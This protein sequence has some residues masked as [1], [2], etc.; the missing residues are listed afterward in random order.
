MAGVKIQIHTRHQASGTV[1]QCINAS[2]S[3]GHAE[4]SG[5]EGTQ[6]TR[7]ASVF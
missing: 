4:C 6:P 7:Q 5:L 1:V 3:E 2:L